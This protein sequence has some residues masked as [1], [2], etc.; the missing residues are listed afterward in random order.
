ML[1]LGLGLCPA[2]PRAFGLR[3]VSATELRAEPQVSPDRTQAAVLLHLRDDH[4]GP[5]ARRRLQLDG[6][7]DGA[8]A[9]RHTLDTDDQGDALARFPLRPTDHV[10]HLRAEFPGDRSHAPATHTLQVNLDAPFVTAEVDAPPVVDQDGPP[11]RVVVRVNV[12]QVAPLNPGGLSVDLSVDDRVRAAGV[13]DVTGRRV[14]MLRPEELGTAG[15]HRLR[16]RVAVQPEVVRGTERSVLVRA[17]VGL[18]LARREGTGVLY[19]ALRTARGPL[20]GAALRIMAGERTLAATTTD[21]Q[22]GFEVALAPSVLTE[23]S[24]RVRAVFDPPEPWL[25]RAESAVVQVTDPPP[26][27][28]AWTWELLALGLAAGLVGVGA[29]VSRRRR[30]GVSEPPEAPLAAVDRIEA[31]K[32]L[33]RGGIHLTVRVKDRATGRA[34]A[35]AYLRWSPTEPWET[36]PEGSLERPATRNLSF[37]VGAPGFAPKAVQGNFH[38]PGEYVVTVALRSW[39]EELFDRGRR[40]LRAGPLGARDLP[41]P[42]EALA[43]APRDAAEARALVTLVEEGCYGPEPPGSREVERADGLL[44]DLGLPP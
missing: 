17:R 16:P 8:S 36:L 13:T 4:R 9:T 34:L 29:A 11:I 6:A 20:G 24:L 1:S 44:K 28:V 37:E 31:V 7:L 25:E 14:F 39:R 30:E 38:R 3:V 10:L 2:E 26:A 21:P 41:T 18:H 19:G 12:G 27:K 42:R 23:P 32:V 33:A 43:R 5:L 15:V 35:A 40:W 22:G